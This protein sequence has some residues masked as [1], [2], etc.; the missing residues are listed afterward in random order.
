MTP[1]PDP[2][3]T[4][5]PARFYPLTAATWTRNIEENPGA[6]R[7][8]PGADDSAAVLQG[9]GVSAFVERCVRVGPV[10][11][12]CSNVAVTGSVTWPQRVRAV[13]ST[14]Q[15]T[16]YRLCLCR[17]S[18]V[19]RSRRRGRGFIHAEVSGARRSSDIPRNTAGR[20]PGR[21]ILHR[22]TFLS[23]TQDRVPSVPCTGCPH[24]AQPGRPSPSSRPAPADQ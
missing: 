19:L 20:I 6:R 13:L 18:S 17:V 16:D 1:T 3:D 12:A 24:A 11:N 4:V 8:R 23:G 10:L 15:T 22:S 21:P 7:R 14:L 2:G 5:S 9:Q